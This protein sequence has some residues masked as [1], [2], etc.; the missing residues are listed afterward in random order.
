VFYFI[1]GTTSEIKQKCSAAKKFLKVLQFLQKIFRE[2]E[3]VG[4]YSWGEVVAANH[5]ICQV[6]WHFDV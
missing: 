4:K 6:T 3:H 1:H 5:S 2:I